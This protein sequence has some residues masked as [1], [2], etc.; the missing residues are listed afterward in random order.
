M[1]SEQFY[2][3]GTKK[4]VTLGTQTPMDI[5]AEWTDLNRKMQER[6]EQKWR[7]EKEKMRMRYWERKLR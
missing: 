2:Q 7:M 1:F 5:G 4:M 3:A 6:S